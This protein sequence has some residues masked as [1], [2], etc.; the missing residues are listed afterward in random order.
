MH[1]GT[2]TRIWNVL[3]IGA[4]LC[5]IGHGAF[6]L[7]RKEAWLP[8]FALFGISA[9]V[10][11]YLMPLVGGVDIAV[12]VLALV[13]PRPVVFAYMAL[14]AIWTAALRPLS[15]D[16]FAELT[17]RAGN[18]GVPMV[19]LLMAWP[20]TSV[21]A[22][23]A[24][25]RCEDLPALDTRRVSQL[26]VA[27]TTLLLAGH[28]FIGLA[29]SPLLAAHYQSVGL[30]ASLVPTI[31]T[32]EISAALA[33]A[34]RPS[35]SLAL[36][37]CGWKLA[38]E[39]LF[40]AAGAPVWEVVE[41]GGSYAAPLALALLLGARRRS[42]PV[43]RRAAAGVI[44]TM[45]AAL[46]PAATEAQPRSSTGSGR[47]LPAAQHDVAAPTERE[48]LAELRR[49]GVVLAC[50]HAITDHDASDRN[51]SNYEDRSLQRN[52]NAEGE[53]QARRM[54]EAIRAL[55][56]PFGEVLTSPM[57]RT[58]ETAE[59]MFGE[60][61]VSRLLRMTPDSAATRALFT[62]VVERGVIRVLMTHTG[63]LMR[64]L[65]GTPFRQVPEG[66]CVLLRPDGGTKPRPAALITEKE[67]EAM[68]R[69]AQ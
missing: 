5:F 14:W 1:N 22:W 3:R 12:G 4:A 33:L 53:A 29:G 66:G 57:A 19:L 23:L 21:R 38:S 9:D 42:A 55:R 62:D 18:Y 25:I 11:H 59:M 41:R 48:L 60:A 47:D 24:R 35:V 39:S 2:T 31:G 28:G 43:A 26:L 40:L 17:E 6:G 27:T 52:L 64:R 20:G 7:L 63:V 15:G 16:S 54:G 32:L 56:L 13:S 37:I 34:L 51:G 30:G 65:E 58:K 50:R 68:R 49:G 8:F 67:W 45:M 44:A 46:L 10:A 36:L 61:V 69:V